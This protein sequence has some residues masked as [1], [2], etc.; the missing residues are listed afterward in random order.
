MR[1]LLLCMAVCVVWVA[2]HDDQRYDKMEPIPLFVDNVIPE[3]NPSESYRYYTLAYCRPA[4]EKHKT[5]SLGEVLQGSR[6]I[7]SPYDIRFDVDVPIQQITAPPVR[8]ATRSSAK[9]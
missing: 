8:R 6:K 9:P 3:N 1:L 5:Q 7:Y 2:A 4:E